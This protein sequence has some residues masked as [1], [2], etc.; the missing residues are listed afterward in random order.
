MSGRVTTVKFVMDRLSSW[1]SDEIVGF[2]DYF[3]G[4][5][6]QAAREKHASC[7]R[8]FED[9]IAALRA[10]RD[11]IRSGGVIEAVTPVPVPLGDST[12]AAVSPAVVDDQPDNGVA[13]DQ[14]AD[15]PTLAEIVQGISRA[16]LEQTNYNTLKD[17]CN[18]LGIE[19]KGNA[20][21]A[22]LI[23]LLTEWQD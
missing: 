7:E 4:M 13:V 14:Q 22:V 6:A 11:E 17:Y 9:A 3:V 18:G 21:R 19:F 10:R 20:S 15:A 8:V 23:D 1:N 16:D 12:D 2:I 5:R